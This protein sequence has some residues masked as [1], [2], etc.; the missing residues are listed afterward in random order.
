MV[1]KKLLEAPT[2]E[3]FEQ[4]TFKVI[5][6]YIMKHSIWRSTL[7]HLL[8]REIGVNNRNVIPLWS[9]GLKVFPE[10]QNNHWHDDNHY[11][12]TGWNGLTIISNKMS[13]L[14]DLLEEEWVNC[15]SHVLIERGRVEA[16]ASKNFFTFR[17]LILHPHQ[18]RI[19]KNREVQGWETDNS[20]FIKL[21]W[22][23]SIYQAKNLQ[24]TDIG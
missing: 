11:L 1:L 9:I 24:N 12:W 20:I 8:W 4:T 18:R 15:M 2:V 22:T 16:V 7:D 17:N 6:W 19:W 13:T 23:K 5:V 14:P 3:V 10:W 21:Y